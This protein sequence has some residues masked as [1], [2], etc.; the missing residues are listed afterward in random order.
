[1]RWRQ[2]SPKPGPFSRSV[3][4]GGRVVI[5]R[6]RVCNGLGETGRSFHVSLDAG[7]KRV[8]QVQ[9]VEEGRWQ[10][11][12]RQDSV[13]LRRQ[14]LIAAIDLLRPPFN[15]LPSQTVPHLRPTPSPSYTPKPFPTLPRANADGRWDRDSRGRSS[16]GQPTLD[17]SCPP[18]SRLLPRFS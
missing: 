14:T 1:M 11:S 2:L 6:S 3:R 9:G 7:R 10:N 13:A 5:A 8:A 12:W 16:V 17:S 4:I 15:P 18:L